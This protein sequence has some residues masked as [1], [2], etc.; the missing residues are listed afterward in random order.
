MQQS[1]LA[2][3]LPDGQLSFPHLRPSLQWLSESQSPSPSPHGDSVVQQLLSYGTP[4]AEQAIN[5]K[6]KSHS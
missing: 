1:A 2:G 3:K 5:T 4:F 6:N